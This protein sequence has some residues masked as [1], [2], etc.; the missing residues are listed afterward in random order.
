MPVTYACCFSLVAN[1]LTLE[2]RM[3]NDLITTTLRAVINNYSG[4][5]KNILDET[6]FFII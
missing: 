6:I 1:Y 4:N 3:K 5:R 2:N